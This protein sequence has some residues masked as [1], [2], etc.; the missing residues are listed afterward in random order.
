MLQQF[1][2]WTVLLPGS[3]YTGWVPDDQAQG[4]QHM[5]AF[6][7]NRTQIQSKVEFLLEFSLLPHR[8]I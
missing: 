8:L 4:G 2:W 1:M 3:H 7:G 5:H 6:G